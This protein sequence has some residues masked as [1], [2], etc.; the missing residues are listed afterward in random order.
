MKEDV[1]PGMIQKLK[2]PGINFDHVFVYSNGFGYS[3]ASG[4]AHY[5]HMGC[6][7][8]NADGTGN[9]PGTSAIGGECS[10][11]PETSV[12]NAP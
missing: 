11:L 10:C 12:E 2:G 9:T 6:T 8:G 4:P 3:Y 7:I 1:I 5:R